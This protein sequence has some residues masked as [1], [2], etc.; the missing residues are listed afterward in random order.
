MGYKEAVELL[1]AKPGIDINAES[2]NGQNA[3]NWAE[4]NGCEEC[5]ALLRQFADRQSAN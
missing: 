5:A 4:S 3:L 1:L 2:D